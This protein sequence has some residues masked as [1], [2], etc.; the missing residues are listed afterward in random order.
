MKSY[1]YFSAKELRCKCGKCDGGEMDA[2]FM[3]RLIFIR[4]AIGVPLKLSSGFRCAEYNNA[5]S[6]TGRTGPHTTG[7]AVD[8]RISGK[9]AH[10]LVRIATQVGMTGIGIAQKGEHKYRFIHIDTLE[11]DTR[12]WVWSY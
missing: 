1:D 11:G 8:I 5:I 6:H 2:A 3:E 4:E 7:K 9:Q 12:P 10:E